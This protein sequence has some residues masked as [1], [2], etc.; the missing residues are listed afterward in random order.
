MVVGETLM[1]QLTD[2]KDVE[3]RLK[4]DVFTSF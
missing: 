4:F 3:K 2:D 1:N